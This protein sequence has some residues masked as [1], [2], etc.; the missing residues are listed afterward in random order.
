ML[1]RQKLKGI[2]VRF[3]IYIQ[4]QFDLVIILETGTVVKLT[5][6]NMQQAAKFAS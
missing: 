4:I 3:L 6:I 1:K 2:D 5:M